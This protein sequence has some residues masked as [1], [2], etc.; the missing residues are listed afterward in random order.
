MN[1]KMTNQFTDIAFNTARNEKPV[2]LNFAASKMSQAVKPNSIV[3]F[4]DFMGRSHKVICRNTPEIK[5]AMAF[6]S[7]LKKE[8]LAITRIIAQY[9]MSYGQVTKKFIPEVRRELKAIGLNNKSI[10]KVLIMYWA[11]FF[12][13]LGFSFLNKLNFL[14]DY[15]FRIYDYRGQYNFCIRIY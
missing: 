10:E 12:D 13:I 8:S 1:S 4:K 14:Y 6:F 3:E 9:P 2:Y 11:Q 5:K 7:E 15:N